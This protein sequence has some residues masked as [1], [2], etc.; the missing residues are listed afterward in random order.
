MQARNERDKLMRM[1]SGEDETAAGDPAF[2]QYP[3]TVQTVEEMLDNFSADQ[4]KLDKSSPV[5]RSLKLWWSGSA[6]QG[7]PP[8]R[9]VPR[10]QFQPD[11]RNK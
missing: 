8:L 1:V 6:I 10:V 2:C 9:L 4:F 11:V 7:I 5:D 3:E